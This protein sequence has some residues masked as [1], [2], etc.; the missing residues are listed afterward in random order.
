[1]EALWKICFM[2]LGA[3]LG[4]TVAVRN[5]DVKLPDKCYT[6][7]DNSLGWSE[8]RS[9][10]QELG[11][12]LAVL[13][14][15]HVRDAVN[16]LAKSGAKLWIGLRKP[17]GNGRPLWV[18]T[19]IP[20]KENKAYP[21]ARSPSSDAEC[22]MGVGNNE[23]VFEWQ[24]SDCRNAES[25]LCEVTESDDALH[26]VKRKTNK[27]KSTRRT[28]RNPSVDNILRINRDLNLFQG[29]IKLTEEQ[30]RRHSAGMPILSNHEKRGITTNDYLYWPGNV[31]HYVFD[32]E[33][34]S[35]GSPISEFGRGII[36]DA[37]DDLEAETCL[38]FTE[39]VADNY[40]S[41][42]NGGG[43]W[44][45]IGKIGGKQELSLYDGNSGSCWWEG[46][47]QH[48]VLHAL[49][50]FHE[51]SRYDRDDYIEIKWDNIKSGTE[52]NFAKEYNMNLQSTMY[53]YGSLMH[54]GLYDFAIDPALPTMVMLQD[55]DGEVGQIN[56]LSLTDIVEVNG[57]YSCY[58]GPGW[59]E[60]SAWSDCTQ[61]C[62]GG[63]Q[64]RYRTCGDESC[65]GSNIDTRTCMIVG[66]PQFTGYIYDG[67]WILPESLP[68]LEG[69][70]NPHLDGEYATRTDKALKCASAATH[71]E[72]LYFALGDGGACYAFSDYG[73]L[74]SA[75]SSDECVEGLGT[76]NSID[77]YQL[78]TFTCPFG[79]PYEFEG[80]MVFCE[81]PDGGPVVPFLDSCPGGYSCTHVS[82]DTDDPIS[83]CCPIRYCG[84][85]CGGVIEER[86]CYCDNL[87]HSWGD[88]CP[89]YIDDCAET[90]NCY[91]S[92][93]PHYKTFDGTYYD[94]QGECE[95]ILMTDGCND[96][97]KFAVIVDN[98]LTSPGSTV[99]YTKQ[100]RIEVY[101][102]VIEL[103][104]LKE[105]KIDGTTVY[106]PITM[107]Y[108]TI[109]DVGLY[110]VVNIGYGFRVSWDGW[111]VIR[112][113]LVSDYLEK[114]CGLCGW[115][116]N[117][118]DVDFV[119]SAMELT[120]D[121][122]VFGNSWETI[123]ECI[124][125][126]GGSDSYS[127]VTDTTRRFVDVG[128]CDLNSQNADQALDIC[129]SLI[130][131]LPECAGTLPPE[132][133]IDACKMDLCD[134]LPG[135][136]AGGCAVLA[137]YV[138]LCQNEGIVISDWRYN[139]AC[140][141]DCPVNM[142]YKTCGPACPAT[143]DEPNPVG[144]CTTQCVEGCFCEDGLI[145]DTGGICIPQ[146]SCGCYKKE[147]RYLFGEQ[148]PNGDT[149]NCEFP[150]TV[151]SGCHFYEVHMDKANWET[152]KA[153]CEANNGRLAKLN[154]KAI[155]N[156]VRRFI[157]DNG[158]SN[159][160]KGF[161]FGLDDIITEGQFV[162]SDGTPL[163]PG[164]F[165][166]WARNQP[167]SKPLKAAV[168]DCV[169]MWDRRGLKWD[170]DK[171]VK[172]KGYICEYD[173]ACF[174]P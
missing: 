114:V 167:S 1:M 85:V 46:I 23:H 80:D 75:G 172:E 83:V 41:M 42:F 136:E 103:L 53:D 2:F 19:T 11:G 87:C 102:M 101:D 134:S 8:A 88:C 94:Y 95:Y 77:V 111:S 71:V 132:V 68:S 39:G 120:S 55:Y 28:H 16:V 162:W 4:S 27:A 113:D 35:E 13:E 141:I 12:D 92:G 150:D 70:G 137:S 25:F 60:W 161:W 127:D 155:W 45:Y 15:E 170:D 142:I 100:A 89:E 104:P 26:I 171:C 115:F 21:W 81:V 166:K 112:V 93:D 30:E 29:D 140:E 34:T 110:L 139:T 73:L 32:E 146:S 43:C 126:E 163:L 91:G 90:A 6:V 66:C 131:A 105:V 149:C 174:E 58:E 9:K 148:L 24:F 97:S 62:G 69:T 76:E 168:Q 153:N 108:L 79:N 31:V 37:L 130:G 18:E 145:F 107:N 125:E 156:L 48:E 118:P 78:Q 129:T 14:S 96:Q 117:N 36:R 50:F 56:G 164:D 74:T 7:P 82:G 116:N 157:M 124:P 123:E 119:T 40:I 5:C 72:E 158:Y 51:Q 151:C 147:T 169:Q 165:T 64:D 67:C 173:N 152:A 154:T 106:P 143:C 57:I 122:Y 138:A 22:V 10:C 17:H 84:D 63:S 44:S 109:K 59:S 99:T 133:F 61:T 159:V 128:P 38:T 98:D 135:D 121:V 20:Y 54:Y 65:E 144:E 47:I 160:L 52:G 33:T 86:L 3:L 49:G